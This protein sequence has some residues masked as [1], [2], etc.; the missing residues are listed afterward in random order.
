MNNSLMLVSSC[1]VSSLTYILYLRKAYYATFLQLFNDIDFADLMNAPRNI[2][3]RDSSFISHF[4]HA[5][6]STRIHSAPIINTFSLQCY[7]SKSWLFW[8][9]KDLNANGFISTVVP[10]GVVITGS[11]QSIVTIPTVRAIVNP[12]DLLYFPP[13]YAHVV[14]STPGKNIMFAF[15]QISPSIFARALR[16]HFSNSI[17]TLTRH[18]VHQFYRKSQKGGFYFSEDPKPFRDAWFEEVR[19]KQEDAFSSYFG[20]DVFG[21]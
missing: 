1:N 5:V 20:F 8:K 9:D 12:N 3:L 15:R 2:F 10:N 21:I 6:V 13:A 17:F 14:A 19:S 4:S 16:T 7:G 11:P 18:F